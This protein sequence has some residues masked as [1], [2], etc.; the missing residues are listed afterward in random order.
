MNHDGELR[1]KTDRK[2]SAGYI[3]KR[4]VKYLK[5]GIVNLIFSMLLMVIS[6]VLGL[7]LPLITLK[8]LN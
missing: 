2:L 6:V 5:P 7:L 8:I 4:N 1:L 3:L